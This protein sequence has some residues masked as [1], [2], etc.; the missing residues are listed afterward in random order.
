MPIHVGVGRAHVQVGETACLTTM[1][2][3]YG[4][5]ISL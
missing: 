3:A 2:H 1:R 5:Q 4:L